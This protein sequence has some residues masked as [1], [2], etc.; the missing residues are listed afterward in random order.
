MNRQVP[1]IKSPIYG[2]IGSGQLSS[3]LQHYFK[4]LDVPYRT[5]ARDFKNQNNTPA[6][7][8]L[9]DCDVI[10]VLISD[11]YIESFITKLLQDAPEFKLKRFVHCSGALVTTLADGIHPLM[12]FTEELYDFETYQSMS[13]VCEKGVDFK[14]VFPSLPNRSFVIEKEFKPL[15]HALC[16]MAGNFSVLLWQELF[17]NFENRLKIPKDAAYPYLEQLTA[18]L[19]KNPWGA[20][21]GPLQRKDQKTITK[22]LESLKDFNIQ[23]IYKSFVEVFGEMPQ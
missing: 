18:N 21:T 15:Y 1:E 17:K 19:Q 9:A 13:F 4:M 16:V 22:N 10:L 5:W 23:K 8:V 7:E 20:L 12:S 6:H 3:H 14:T 2:V 11:S